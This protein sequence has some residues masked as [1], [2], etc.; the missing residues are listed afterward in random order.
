M[1]TLKDENGNSVTID[2]DKLRMTVDGKTSEWQF[3]M[4]GKPLWIEWMFCHL[5]DHQ[6]VSQLSQVLIQRT[7]GGNTNESSNTTSVSMAG[8][9]RDDKTKRPSYGFQFFSQKIGTDTKEFSVAL[10]IDAETCAWSC[11]LIAEDKVIAF[12]TNPARSTNAIFNGLN[13]SVGIPSG[14]TAYKQ[15]A[16]WNAMYSYL[17]EIADWY[18]WLDGKQSDDLRDTNENYNMWRAKLQLTLVQMLNSAG[19]DDKSLINQMLGLLENEHPSPEQI[20]QI[21]LKFDDLHLR[22]GTKVP[23]DVRK[24]IM[25]TP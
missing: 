24:Q 9:Y 11:Q 12:R 10:S 25:S 23:N 20:K 22:Y 5:N 15:Q 8:P 1:L 3:T 4:D 13:Q 19:P 7:Q 14:A 2:H 18:L 6:I 16:W 21:W 17:N